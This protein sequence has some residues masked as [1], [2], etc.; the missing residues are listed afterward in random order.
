MFGQK[1][2]QSMSTIY[3]VAHTNEVD[4]DRGGSRKYFFCNGDRKSRLVPNRCIHGI[5]I[6]NFPMTIAII[7]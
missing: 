1:D 6:Q 7:S 4:C 3:D 2:L 5:Y